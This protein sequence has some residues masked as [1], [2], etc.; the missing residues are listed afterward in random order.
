[1]ADQHWSTQAQQQPDHITGM[2]FGGSPGCKTMFHL[3]QT[4][5]VEI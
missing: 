5:F 1:M 4:I 3:F 2:N